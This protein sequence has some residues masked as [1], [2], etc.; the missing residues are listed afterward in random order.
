MYIPELKSRE[1][2]EEHEDE[3]EDEDVE[4]GWKGWVVVAVSFFC[5][6]ILDGVGYTTGTTLITRRTS[7]PKVEWK[8]KF[9][10]FKVNTT[11]NPISRS[12]NQPTGLHEGP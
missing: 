7:D 4:G 6:A 11:D 9:P 8:F 10:P 5:I 12:T 1:E 3:G 2:G